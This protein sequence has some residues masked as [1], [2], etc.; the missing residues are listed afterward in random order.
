[1]AFHVKNPE[2]ERLA[3]KL[4]AIRGAGLTEAVTVALRNELEREEGKPDFVEQALAFSRRL[5]AKGRPELRQPVDR[6]YIDSLYE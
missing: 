2:T 6:A 1:M 3:R 4:A 5:K